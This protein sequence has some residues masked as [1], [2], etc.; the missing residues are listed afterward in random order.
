MSPSKRGVEELKDKMVHLFEYHCECGYFTMKTHLNH[1]CDDLGRFR[2]MQSLDAASYGHSNVVLR[3]AYRR[4]Y[5]RGVSRR[6]EMASAL[7]PIIQRLEM[8]GN[9]GERTD[10]SLVKATW[11]Q[12]V[13][14]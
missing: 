3:R 1:L 2:S 10:Q 12:T 8:K 14:E 13:R 6:Q 4:T 7:K 5:M 9:D 11:L